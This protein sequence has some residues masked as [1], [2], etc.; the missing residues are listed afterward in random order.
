MKGRFLPLLLALALLAGCSVFRR[1]QRPPYRKLSAPVAY[2]IMRDNP[3][4]LIIDLRAPRDFNGH[5]GH[6]RR[7]RNIPLER[8]PFRLLEI[9]TFRDETFLVYCDTAECAKAGMEILTSS[10]FEN[11]VLMEGGVDAW[12]NGGFK[13]VLPAEAAGRAGANGNGE[14]PVRPLRP[15]EKPGEK[16]VEPSPPPPEMVAAPRQIG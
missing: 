8:L 4:M 12:I 7:A 3:D 1:G 11:A 6:L 5:T 16:T 13:T 9:S 15:D 2:E 14:A 10:G